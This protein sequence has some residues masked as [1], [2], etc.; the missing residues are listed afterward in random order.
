MSGERY[1]A[2]ITVEGKK[3]DRYRRVA[4]AKYMQYLGERQ[5]VIQRIYANRGNEPHAAHIEEPA[6]APEQN[7]PLQET[8]I[9]DLTQI[10]MGGV[11]AD[12]LFSLPRG[13]SIAVTLTGTQEVDLVL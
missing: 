2:L 11:T 9:F 4:L 1:S 10:E 3:Y 6:P 8:S 7:T 12:D 13:E 5:S